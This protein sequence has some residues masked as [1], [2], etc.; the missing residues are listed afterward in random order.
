MVLD[1]QPLF[2]RMHSQHAIREVEIAVAASARE[3]DTLGW[4]EDGEKLGLIFSGLGPNQEKNAQIILSRFTAALHQC[5]KDISSVEI[6]FEV[7]SHKE[8]P[9]IERAAFSSM[10][11][12]AA[13]ASAAGNSF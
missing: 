10:D 12:R 3:T 2:Q 6:S 4:Y 11:L 8:I 1:L 13:A 7:F 5:S 9:Q